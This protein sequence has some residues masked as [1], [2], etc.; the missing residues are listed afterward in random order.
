MFR[1]FLIFFLS[2]LEVFGV[3]PKLLPV[4]VARV[5]LNWRGGGGGMRDCKLEVEDV[6]REL[7]VEGDRKGGRVAPC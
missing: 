6:N 7:S 3:A 5:M 2:C 4:F 1:S